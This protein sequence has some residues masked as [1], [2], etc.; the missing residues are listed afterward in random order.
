MDKLEKANR[1]LRKILL[2]DNTS[3]EVFFHN[4][5]YY[6]LNY[7]SEFQA[8]RGQTIATRQ[9]VDKLIEVFQ[10]Q[11]VI[12]PTLII[13][14]YKELVAEG[15]NFISI[16]GYVQII[17][18]ENFKVKHKNQIC[19]TLKVHFAMIFDNVLN[20]FINSEELVDQYPFISNI[21]K[22]I[23]LQ[24]CVEQ[25]IERRQIDI[26]Y[27]LGDDMFINIEV[28]E[29]MHNKE[30]DR[31]RKAEIYS[32][33]QRK[34]ILYYIEE[35]LIE[36][37][38]YE[39][40]EEITRYL[41]KVSEYLGF[42]FHLLNRK[43]IVDVSTCVRFVSIRE[44]ADNDKFTV[45]ILCS[46]FKFVG[47]E[48]PVECLKKIVSRGGIRPDLF[49]TATL[50][51]EDCSVALMALTRED[52]IRNLEI[53]TM[54]ARFTSEY[55]NFAKKFYKDGQE[56]E[57]LYLD[58]LITQDSQSPKCGIIKGLLNAIHDR[59]NIIKEKLGINLHPYIPFLYEKKYKGRPLLGK[60]VEERCNNYGYPFCS[61]WLENMNSVKGYRFLDEEISPLIINQLL[62]PV[63]SNDLD[64]D[65]DEEE[66]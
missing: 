17:F 9:F 48:N 54:F 37:I 51:F 22:N 18:P 32:T 15:F 47:V 38:L 5:Y 35:Q 23:Y 62:V 33:K 66:F 19:E 4:Q 65:S 43:I 2:Y 21:K 57:Q 42:T 61:D 64:N 31:F 56:H 50:T 28:N 39:V 24:V 41:F 16:S 34:L 53:T 45:D 8:L 29:K 25:R 10:T 11:R 13:L 3:K 52:T 26:V 1:E 55:F 14:F 59:R 36:D 40:R 30:Q 49:T 46:L 6:L 63:S 27:N 7:P 20:D 60:T 44:Y 12:N 58:Y